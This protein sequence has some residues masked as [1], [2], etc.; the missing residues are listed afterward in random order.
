MK[1][2]LRNRSG[3]VFP[4][5]LAGILA[6]ASAS[7]STIFYN[8]LLSN[9]SFEL[10]TSL[11]TCPTD[12]TCGGPAGSGLVGTYAPT[13]LEYVAG[14]DGLSGS[15]NAPFGNNVATTPV[16]VEGSGSMY[17]TGIG[18]YLAGNTYTLD[19][20]VGT[21]LV[22]PS[23]TSSPAAQVGVITLYILGTAGTA[24]PLTSFSVTPSATPGQWTFEQF[25][26]TPTGSQIGQSI[27]MELFVGSQGNFG[28]GNNRIADFDI[29]TV[30]EPGTIGL[31]GLGLLGLGVLRRKRAL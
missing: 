22:V 17:Q 21:P 27:G 28:S 20:W 13:N 2:L 10:S 16:P 29:G 4:L 8:N 19:L 9:P 12:W 24:T 15:E 23:V 18:T 30:P 11:T 25:S 5:V 31:L 1:M 7:G 14:S 6:A 26:F 3:L